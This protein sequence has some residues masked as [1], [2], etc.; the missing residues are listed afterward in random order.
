MH[1]LL[2]FFSLALLLLNSGHRPSAIAA[3]AV[4]LTRYILLT[5]H[6]HRTTLAQLD[7]LR[8]AAVLER[9]P[10]TSH[11]RAKTSI[12]VQRLP[13]STV[14][15][16]SQ[17]AWPRAMAYLTRFALPTLSGCILSMNHMLICAMGFGANL[18]NPFLGSPQPGVGEGLLATQTATDDAP[19]PMK[20]L[21][22]KYAGPAYDAIVDRFLP[23]FDLTAEL[24][25]DELNNNHEWLPMM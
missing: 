1:F 8:D 16:A 14:L 24:L 17:T 21:Y 23:P 7:A 18:A 22:L 15:N 11:F 4:F 5:H 6:A 19:A 2:H 9:G 12:Q 13:R 20:A 25:C 3:A 10:L